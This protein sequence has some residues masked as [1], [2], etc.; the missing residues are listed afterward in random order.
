MSNNKSAA[1][2]ERQSTVGIQGCAFLSAIS[3]LPPGLRAELSERSLNIFGDERTFF[4]ISRDSCFGSRM[5]LPHQ[6]SILLEAFLQFESFRYILLHH[7]Q[8]RTLFWTR[9]LLNR[10]PLDNACWFILD[11]RYNAHLQGLLTRQF[12]PP[13][14]LFSC[15]V[16][17]LHPC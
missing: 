10:L 4:R 14:T 16:T 12:P 15:Q 2:R 13:C 9:P 6:K 5:T 7:S 1:S 8:L 3:N 17:K 11:H